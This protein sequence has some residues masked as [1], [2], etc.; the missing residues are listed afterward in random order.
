LDSVK[1]EKSP[2]YKKIIGMKLAVARAIPT[3]FRA[4]AVTL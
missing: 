2:F 1:Y 3:R 4:G